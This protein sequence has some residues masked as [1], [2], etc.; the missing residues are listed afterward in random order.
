M[1]I[2]RVRAWLPGMLGLLC[3]ASAAWAGLPR[4]GT[5]P[6]ALEI[7]STRVQYAE[8]D[9]R[10]VYG[11]LSTP[12]D[13]QKAA[14]GVLLIH[15]WWGLDRHMRAETKRLAR[16]G[17]AALAVDL[18]RGQVTRERPVA[19][20]LA[21]IA[22]SDAGDRLANLEQAVNYLSKRRQATRI[23]VVGW[24][25]GGRWALKL[26]S[27]LPQ[28]I[29]ALAIFYA[30]PYTEPSQLAPL[31]MPV[32]AFFGGRDPFVPEQVVAKFQWAAGLAST[33]ADIHVYPDAQA[34]FDNPE[35]TAY[36]QADARDAERQLDEF[37]AEHLQ[38]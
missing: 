12:A 11:Y 7:H 23:G 9:G 4:D 30:P 29:D 26:A 13:G 27:D 22:D 19:A 31:R 17:Y 24:S 20:R 2:W 38:H 5:A 8:I 1:K 37:L 6:P 33:R 16:L 25:M 36:N 15:A 14:A 10:A 18:F 34:D 21:D 35:S 28:A 32:L 3:T